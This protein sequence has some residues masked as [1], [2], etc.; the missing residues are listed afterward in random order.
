MCDL[1]RNLE[2]FF[3]SVGYSRIKIA[4]IADSLLKLQIK[5]GVHL[6]N[7]SFTNEI[8][9]NYVIFVTLL[10][11]ILDKFGFI[12]NMLHKIRNS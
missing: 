4:H 7:V 9:H 1:I 2:D 11:T 6:M 12:L 3:Y 10:F 8:A 5:I